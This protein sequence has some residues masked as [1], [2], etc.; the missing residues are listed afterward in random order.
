MISGG[1][2][3]GSDVHSHQLLTY[4]DLEMLKLDEN[5]MKTRRRIFHTILC[6]ATCLKFTMHLLQVWG[7]KVHIYI[8][9]VHFRVKLFHFSP[10]HDFKFVLSYAN[11]N[12][13]SQKR[14]KSS[15]IIYFCLSIA[16]DRFFRTKFGNWYETFRGWNS[17][18]TNKTINTVTQSRQAV[19]SSV[20]WV[21]T[22]NWIFTTNR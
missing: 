5:S 18:L 4:F 19:L 10:Q 8:F 7:I 2:I 12:L 11:E 14:C 9:Y 13:H 21:N 1:I 16:L 15:S 3:I 17:I 20:I 22:L 6:V